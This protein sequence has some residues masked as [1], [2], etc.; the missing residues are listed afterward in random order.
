MSD[1]ITDILDPATADVVP[2]PA[3]LR[4]AA[5]VDAGARAKYPEPA[6]PGPDEQRRLDAQNEPT[7]TARRMPGDVLLLDS[8]P[9]QPALAS[10]AL[11]ELVAPSCDTRAKMNLL[12]NGFLRRGQCGTINGP[13]GIGKSSLTMQAALCW[14]VGRD[15]F[16]FRP[17]GP[18]RVLIV[19]AENDD[20]D[21]VEMRDGI[22]AA[23][24]FSDSERALALENVRVLRSFSS[25]P[26][27]LAEITP[28]VEKHRPDL[29]IVDPLFAFA[30]VDVA[31]DQPG[32]SRFLRELNLPFMIKHNLGIIYVHHVNKPPA[33]KD[34]TGWQGSD[35]AYSGS[36]HNE[37]ANFPR[38]VIV[39]RS[40]GSRSVFELRLGKRWKRAGIADAAGNPVDRILVKHAEHGIFW[41][42]ATETD[43][44]D[45]IEQDTQQGA[46]AKS[47]P[48]DTEKLAAAFFAIQKDGVASLEKL[49][50]RLKTSERTVRRRFGDTRILRVGDEVFALDQSTIRLVEPT[51]SVVD[52]DF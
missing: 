19:Q 43:L 3:D 46:A 52:H 42:P 34:R 39:L 30:G 2:P 13:T 44:R 40:L 38:F 29:L 31:K 1:A 10:V 18:L 9:Q 14:G 17:Q 11:L 21:L 28:E 49:A 32:L 26:K 8:E 25:G 20:T 41:E 27:W 33:G 12:G 48:G 23:L 15:S 16:G 35:Y 45:S 50:K 7:A 5:A 36:G 6:A 24:N 4:E 47:G 22:L 51:D 37:L